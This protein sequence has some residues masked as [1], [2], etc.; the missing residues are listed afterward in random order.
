MKV[1]WTRTS[2]V[3]TNWR[4]GCEKSQHSGRQHRSAK[5]HH[6]FKSGARNEQCRPSCTWWPHEANRVVLLGISLGGVFAPALAREKAVRGIVVFGTL[7]TRPPAYPGRSER[8]FTEFDAVDVPA[9]WAA[10][11]TRLMRHG[12]GDLGIERRGPGFP[13][14]ARLSSIVRRFLLCVV[15]HCNENRSGG[16]RRSSA[17][18]GHDVAARTE[19]RRRSWLPDRGREATPRTRARRA[20]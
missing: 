1:W 17:K 11:D 4:A 19:P 13:A 9:A 18:G 10:I 5:P 15:L 12:P 8:F 6:G 14:D 7:A 20:C 2:P 16:H 3:G